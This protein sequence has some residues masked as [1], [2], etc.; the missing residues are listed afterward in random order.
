MNEKRRRSV[1]GGNSQPDSEG[2]FVSEEPRN[3]EGKSATPIPLSV[4]EQ[5]NF[6][7]TRKSASSP[8]HRHGQVSYRGFPNDLTDTIRM[9]AKELQ[10]GVDEVVRAMLEY[11]LGTYW[12]GRLTLDPSPAKIKMTLYPKNSKAKATAIQNK[13]QKRKKTQAPR[14]TTVVTFRGIP[15]PVQVAVKQIAEEHD[16]PVGEVAAYL[17]EYGIIA[18]RNGELVLRP[19]PMPDANTL[20]SE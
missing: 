9:A 8:R 16:I 4:V 11:A 10:V 15:Q 1:F 14:W 13:G 12:S 7:K 18:F 5:L 20:Y 19:V 6:A 17:I 2:F 3:D